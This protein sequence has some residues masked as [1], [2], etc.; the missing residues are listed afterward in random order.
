MPEVL[1]Q[2]HLANFNRTSQKAYLGERDSNFL[3]N[4]L[5]ILTFWMHCRPFF[6]TSR[7][8]IKPSGGYLLLHQWFNVT[9]NKPSLWWIYYLVSVCYKHFI[10]VSFNGI[11]IYPF[12]LVNKV[13]QFTVQVFGLYWSNFRSLIS[14][15]NITG[16]EIFNRI[17]SSQI[18]RPWQEA[19]ILWHFIT[20]LMV[21][22]LFVYGSLQIFI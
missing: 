5:K 20:F 12:S 21:Q 7:C 6:S 22:V 3:S 15:S 8:Y 10:S 11:L 4:I 19:Y 2:N 14:Y 18:L 1:L 13:W 17:F 9:C 16:Q